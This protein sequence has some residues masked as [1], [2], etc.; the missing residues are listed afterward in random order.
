MFL[1][2]VEAIFLRAMEHSLKSS[3]SEAMPI[4]RITAGGFP[5]LRGWGTTP[6]DHQHGGGVIWTEA[7]RPRVGNPLVMRGR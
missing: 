1:S 4:F 7:E 2:Y 3:F 5:K 6:R